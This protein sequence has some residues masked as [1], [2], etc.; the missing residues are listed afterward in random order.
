MLL[1]LSVEQLFLLAE[2]MMTKK[3][4]HFGHMNKHKVGIKSQK[5]QPLGE[6]YTTLKFIVVR[7]KQS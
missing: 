1:V 2:Q 6:G 7:F 3:T 4:Y 5:M